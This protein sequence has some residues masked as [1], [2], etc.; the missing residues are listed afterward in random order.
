MTNSGTGWYGPSGMGGNELKD[1][2]KKEVT[3]NEAKYTEHNITQAP[4]TQR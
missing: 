3:T 4:V 2:H 1:N